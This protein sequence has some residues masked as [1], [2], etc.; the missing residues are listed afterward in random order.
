MAGS[1]Q[2]QMFFDVSVFR[3]PGVLTKMPRNEGITKTEPTKYQEFRWPNG[4]DNLSD[5]TPTMGVVIPSVTW[6]DSNARPVTF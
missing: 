3:K 4:Q 6:P 2:Y 1:T 5:N